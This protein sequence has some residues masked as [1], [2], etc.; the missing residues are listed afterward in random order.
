MRKLSTDELKEILA[1]IRGTIWE[2]FKEKKE[3]K[4]E[5]QEDIQKNL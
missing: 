3:V 2:I 5:K 1:E 4:D